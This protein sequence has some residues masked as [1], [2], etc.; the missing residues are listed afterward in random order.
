KCSFK[1][2]SPITENLLVD[3]TY[4]PL[5]GGPMERVGGTGP[6]LWA[7]RKW[8]FSVCL[9]GLLGDASIALQS[10][11]L[12]DNGTFICSVKNPPDVY[13]N[14]PQTVLLVTERGKAPCPD[15]GLT[16]VRGG[17]LLKVDWLHKAGEEMVFYYYSSHGVPVGRFRS[18]VQWQGDVSR[19]DGSIRLHDLRLNDSGT[20]EC[21]MRLLEDSSI[22]RSQTELLVSSAP[23]GPCAWPSFAL[24]VSGVRLQLRRCW[25]AI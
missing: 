10:P 6:G 4:R 20:Y 24:A 1:S 21:E 14:V 8:E 3:W 13:H 25:G 23:R 22:F 15:F 9:A 12:S 16:P 5:T 18:R 7:R 11:A 17:T 2:S 19:R